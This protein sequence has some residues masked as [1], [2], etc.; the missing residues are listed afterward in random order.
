MMK[1][2]WIV[3]LLLLLPS[4]AWGACPETCPATPADCYTGT[5]TKVVCD[6]SRGAVAATIGAADYGDTISIPAGTGTGWTSGITITKDIKVQGAGTSSTFIDYDITGTETGVFIF[7]P[8]AQAET[9][10]ETLLSSGLF[11]ITGITFTNLTVTSEAAGKNVEILKIPGV[12]ISKV[13]KKIRFHNNRVFYAHHILG[14]EIGRSHGLIDN[15]YLFNSAF[16]YAGASSY[17]TDNIIHLGSGGGWYVEDNISEFS[18]SSMRRGTSDT[19][20]VLT[21]EFKYWLGHTLYTKTSVETVLPEGTV[22][23]GKFGIFSMFIDSAGT[24]TMLAGA[25]NATGYA[26]AAAA[27]AA[28]PA[29]PENTLY[30]GGFTVQNASG[31]DFT[32]GTTALNA[33]GITTVFGENHYDGFVIGGGNNS[34][35]AMTVRYN[36]AYGT[37][38]YCTDYSA[39]AYTGAGAV[40]FD[41]HSNQTTIPGGQY[42]KVYGNN[43][44]PTLYDGNINVITQNRGQKNLFLYNLFP[45]NCET[46]TDIV[47]REEL[48]DYYSID[49]SP[50]YDA[51]EKAALDA[52]YM[53]ESRTTYNGEPSP[54][55]CPGY[56]IALPDRTATRCGCW[57]VHDSYV[58]NNR[59]VGGDA[60]SSSIEK[61]GAEDFDYFD[62]TGGTLNDPPEIAENREFFNY[63]ALG[64]FDGSAGVTCGTTAQMNAITPTTTGVGFWVPANIATMPCTEVLAN[65]IK[66]TE[67]V[68]PVTPI[69]GTLYKWDGD[70]WEAF[71][72]P[73]TYPHPLR[74]EG[75]S[76]GSGHSF[77]GGATHSFSGGSTITWQ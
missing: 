41:N 25:D 11:E 28:R 15:N 29:T 52:L 60:L 10:I 1:F 64:S 75:G 37:P 50:E 23:N 42:L 74:G 68:N 58:F 33:S 2:K 46:S 62:G 4:L 7:S 57:K 67:G 65:N 73:Y 18:A 5:T 16:Y 54:Q 14:S 27:I 71:W 66:Q 12:D 36:K 51:S 22:P 43:F 77:S 26:D 35:M 9:N 38:P 76:G 20:K 39:T 6:V 45:A 19:K 24:I 32:N 40:Y 55:V 56:Y 8:D 21:S 61:Y 53:C 69:T 72:V 13:I 47:F 70:S 3:A 17:Y 44:L 49:A 63:V 34:G 30:L 59:K 31:G 48:N